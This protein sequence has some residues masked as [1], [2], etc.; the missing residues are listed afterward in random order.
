MKPSY[1]ELEKKVRDL[2]K[3]VQKY[4]KTVHHEDERDG[5]WNDS[6]IFPV[7]DDTNEVSN[8]AVTGFDITE[9]KRMEEELKEKEEVFRLFM[10]HSPIYMFFKDRNIRSLYLSK[11]YEK[12]LGRPINELLYKNMDELFPSD[13]AKSMIADDQAILREGKVIQVQETFNGRFYETI[14]FPIHKNGTPAYLAGFTM[15]ITDRKKSETAMA[16]SEQKWRNILA[17]T[18][19]IGVSLDTGARIVFANDH[20]LKLTG[21]KR[22]EIIGKEWFSLFIPENIREGVRGIFKQVMTLKEPSGFSNY[23]NEILTK[24]GELLNVAWSNVITRDTRGSIIDVTCLGIDL[25]ERKRAEEKIRQSETRYRFMMESFIDPLY[26]CSPDLKISYINP[27]MIRRIGR[28]ATGE[29]CYHVM[30][31]QDHPCDWCV[32]DTV[33]SNTAAEINI[34][35]PLDGRD[36]R[37][38]N[39]PIHHEDGTISKMTV[40]R[41]IT[42]YLKVVD[43]KEKA[44]AQLAQSQKMESIGTLAGGIAHEFNNILSIIMG[45]NEL[46][47]DELPEWSQARTSLDEIRIACLRARDVVRQLLTFSRKD[48]AKKISMDIGS[49]VKESLKLI[50][51][52]IPA[53]I[54]IR[55]TISDDIAPIIGNATQINQVLINLC[56]NAAD[57]MREKGGSLQIDLGNFLIDE[58]T[59]PAELSPGLYVRLMISDTG[60]GMDHDTLKRMFEPFFTTK[61]IGKGTG[62][63]L[64]VVHGIVERH[65]GSIQVESK[66][67]KGTLFTILFPAGRDRINQPDEEQS[68]LPGGNERILFVDDEPILMTLGKKR[69]EM[70]GYRVHG[71]T[72]P[73]KALKLFKT[74]PAA[75]DL[76]ITDMAM[77]GMTGDQLVSEILEIQPKL[78]AMLCTGYS[79]TLSEKKAYEIGFSAFLLKP[80]DKTELAV[81]VRK[82]LDK[83]KA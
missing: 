12:M 3:I 78:P 10:E 52:S 59:R 6:I 77:P 22:Q 72:D 27:A 70:L 30:H 73:L 53:N 68:I 2:E 58:K 60:D 79:E 5:M 56:G 19:Q 80:V 33:S 62:I 9:R 61:E 81:A 75:F 38:T 71:E 40:F 54:D 50:R 1:E 74:D 34:K 20:F 13:L 21:W 26:I 48:D 51:S 25:T 63:G 29:T 17:N 57:A 16:E 39:M 37:V 45:N 82:A 67:E 42:D 64:A 35:S 36:Y 24:N 65:N 46:A 43:E 31:G 41:D 47:M 15:D 28:D 83:A 18:P 11:N 23:E 14:K 4:E 44:Q 32:F 69:L 7:L 49:V 66:P 8:V 55:H 76:L